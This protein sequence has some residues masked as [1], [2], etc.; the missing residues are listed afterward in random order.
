M[1]VFESGRDSN[2]GAAVSNA[3][4][5]S[6]DLRQRPKCGHRPGVGLVPTFQVGDPVRIVHF[7]RATRYVTG[8]KTPKVGETGKVHH[9]VRSLLGLFYVVESLD[10]D[11]TLNWLCEFG[12]REI[13]LA[14][15]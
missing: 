4:G 15:H 11:G 5:F 8:P 9:I 10:G 1:I 3:E 6:K 7:R 12:E 14:T 2:D 13:E